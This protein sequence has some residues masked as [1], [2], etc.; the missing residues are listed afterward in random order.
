MSMAVYLEAREPLLDHKLLEFAARVSMSLKLKNGQSKYLL[1]RVLERRVPRSITGRPKRGFEAPIG[2]WLR[3]PLAPMANEL[4]LDGRLATAAS[5][6]RAKS[7]CSGR[8]TEADARSIPTGSGSWSCWSCGSGA[9]S[10]PHLERCR[11]AATA[12]PPGSRLTL[13]G[14]GRPDSHGGDVTLCAG[15]QASSRRTGCTRT[16]AAAPST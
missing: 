13:V 5:S 6:S 12:P 7:P 11:S 16:I 15:L 2:E 3:G 4:L 8:S 1:R 14:D 10:T 9:S